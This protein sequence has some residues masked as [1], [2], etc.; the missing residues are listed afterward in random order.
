MAQSFNNSPFGPPRD[1][2]NINVRSGGSVQDYLDRLFF[3]TFPD[4][5]AEVSG[6]WSPAGGTVVSIGG[7]SW[8]NIP[9]G[10]ALYGTDPI[11]ALP[12]W[13]AAGARHFE[14]HGAVGD[15]VDAATLGTD[16]TTAIQEAIDAQDAAGGGNVYG[17]QR[18]RVTATIDVPRGITLSTLP[19]ARSAN[20]SST[21]EGQIVGHHTTG[22]VIRME[23]NWANLENLYIGATTTRIAAALNNSGEDTNCGV[24]IAPPDSA[25]ATVKHITL[26]NLVVADQPGG[27]VLVEGESV[28]I[29][30]DTVTTPRSGGHGIGISGG[31]RTG[32]TNRARPG[33]ITILH[34][35]AFDCDGHGLSIGD[36]SDTSS[37]LPFRVLIMNH[38]AFR[39]GLDAGVRHQAS[40]N[41]CFAE[42]VTN[43]GSAAAGTTTGNTADKLAW[44]VAGRSNEFANNRWI[45]A[46]GSYLEIDSIAGFST[47]V[48]IVRG[49][50]GVTTGSATQFAT[51]T[52]GPSFVFIEDVNHDATN[53]TSTPS[54][55]T[56]MVT[57]ADGK[58][59]FYNYNVET[60]NADAVR[61]RT[62]SSG[63]ITMPS[64]RPHTGRWIIDV[65]T[66]S[67]AASDDLDD[68]DTTNMAV[69]DIVILGQSNSGRAVT[70]RHASGGGNIRLASGT[71]FDMSATG[72]GNTSQNNLVLWYNGANMI[73]LSRA[74]IGA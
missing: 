23:E 43:I 4:F 30:L 25:S 74:L 3:E 50:T 67:A 66:E 6:G 15:Y 39:C 37:T 32:R 16:D 2:E 10:H 44:W 1:A 11:S 18:Y 42:N 53:L 49:G 52:N 65:D 47:E 58:T 12:G 41:Y 7:L 8:V 31:A 64:D 20:V 72:P 22:P 38:E 60:P 35:E 34:G 54:S 36:P 62:I 26:T 56:E 59:S 29:K 55:Q 28:N 9:V 73:E 51:L 69:G 19:P 70:V 63:V 21:E 17:L 57:R 27:G 71:S 24:L 46:S 5:V 14:H 45:N 40:C 33:I 68:I 61:V 13:E 48:I